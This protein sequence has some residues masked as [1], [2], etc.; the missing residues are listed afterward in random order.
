MS[1]GLIRVQS[2]QKEM[3]VPTEIDTRFCDYGI[4]EGVTNLATIGSF[5]AFLQMRPHGFQHN[6]EFLKDSGSRGSEPVRWLSCAQLLV[7]IQSR[8]LIARINRRANE[9]PVVKFYLALNW[10]KQLQCRRGSICSLE[11]IARHD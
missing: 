3:S 8:S 5:T 1:S 9:Q 11:G 10:G 2:L 7:R 4:P 6:R